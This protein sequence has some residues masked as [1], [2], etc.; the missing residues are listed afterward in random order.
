[1]IELTEVAIERIG[2]PPPIFLSLLKTEARRKVSVYSFFTLL[3]SLTVINSMIA[4]DYYT[5]KMFIPEKL[6]RD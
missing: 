6:N 3:K 5:N 2:S 4:Q 1:M